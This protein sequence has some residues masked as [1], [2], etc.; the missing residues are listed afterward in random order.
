MKGIFLKLMFKKKRA[1]LQ[2]Y[3]VFTM[4][5]S[6]CLK[7]WKLEKLKNLYDQK[8]YVVEIKDL[9]QTLNHG[10]VLKKVHRVIKFKNLVN[11]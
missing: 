5:Y 4:T 3:M 7:N 1:I 9:K 6:F 10:P 2:N 8:E 11:I